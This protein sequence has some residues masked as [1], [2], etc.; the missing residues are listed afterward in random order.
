MCIATR[1]VCCL[2]RQSVVSIFT[3]LTYSLYWK[4]KKKRT[5]VT[6][7]LDEIEGREGEYLREGIRGQ[8]P[9]SNPPKSWSF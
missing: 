1:A 3:I 7:V 6:Q 8:N 9:L 2:Q 4:K 5:N